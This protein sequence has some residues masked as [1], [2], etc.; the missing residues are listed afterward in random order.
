MRGLVVNSLVHWTLINEL[1]KS[2]QLEEIILYSSCSASASS[3]SSSSSSP[4][5]LVLDW[6]TTQTLEF[7][8]IYFDYREEIGT[9]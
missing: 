3:P 5:S 4:T 7:R 6:K 8:D 9:C 1:L 2:G